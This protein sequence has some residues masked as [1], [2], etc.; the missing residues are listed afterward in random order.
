M[1]CSDS[2]T[3][4]RLY[5]TLNGSFQIER[6]GKILRQG[7]QPYAAAEKYNDLSDELTNK[8]PS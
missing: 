4:L 6:E 1:Y 5:A 3:G 2:N 8:I 7:I